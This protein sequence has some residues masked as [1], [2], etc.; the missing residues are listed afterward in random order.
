MRDRGAYK[1]MK[2]DG[3]NAVVLWRMMLCLLYLDENTYARKLESFRCEE[4]EFLIRYDASLTGI[5][6]STYD[7]RHGSEILLSVSAYEFTFDLNQEARFQ[8]IAEFIAVVAGCISLVYLGHRGFR[9]KLVGDSVAS[10]VW[11]LTERFRSLP[12]KYA[13]LVYISLAVAFDIHVTNTEHLPG[14]LNV[15]HDGL[16]RG[17]S[18]ASMGFDVSK[19]LDLTIQPIC[20]LITLC[21]PTND[22]SRDMISAWRM[23]LPLIDDLREYN[24]QHTQALPLEPA[25]SPRSV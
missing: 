14:V 20:T 21:D 7:I 25:S 18:I 9:V 23:I 17:Q 24:S 3:K 19:S 10:L 15:Q 6:I 13:A 12:G 11:S 1:D 22:E 8:T 2:E 5:G 16:S 4:P